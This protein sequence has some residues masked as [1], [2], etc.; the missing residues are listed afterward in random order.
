MPPARLTTTA[1]VR[2]A[3]LEPDE[4]GHLGPEPTDA[5][6]GGS[7]K[8][9]ARLTGRQS[10][11][12][13]GKVDSLVDRLRRRPVAGPVLGGDTHGSEA[14]QATWQARQGTL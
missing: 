9:L 10:E 11:L 5:G 4:A 7:R 14:A 12:L 8:R 6:R 2:E 3:R 1:G 13:P